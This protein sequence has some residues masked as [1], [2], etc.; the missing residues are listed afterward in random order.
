MVPVNMCD[1]VSQY[2]K[3]KVCELFKWCCPPKCPAC[4]KRG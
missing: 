3:K 2:C 4:G 1:K